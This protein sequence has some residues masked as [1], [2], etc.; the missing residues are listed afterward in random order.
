VFFLQL[1][2]EAHGW[3]THMPRLVERYNA[4]LEQ[5]KEESTGPALAEAVRKELEQVDAAM[6][7]ELEAVERLPLPAAE[8]A[9]KQA[10]VRAEYEQKIRPRRQQNVEITAREKVIEYERNYRPDTSPLGLLWHFLTH[11]P[12]DRPQDSGVWPALLGS[13]LVALITVLFAVPVGVAA[14]LYLEE[15]RQQGRLN[16]LIQVNINNLAGV[17]SVV[18]GILGAFVFVELIFKPIEAAGADIAAR[19][20]LG[21]GL[22][23]G[24]LTLPVIIVAAQEAIRAVPGSIRHGAFALGATRWQVIWHHVLPL[25]RPG[26]M[27]GTILSLSRAVGE[28]APLVLF[29]A[30]LFV[31]EDPGLFSRFTILPMQIFGWADLPA[32][33]VGGE[34]VEIWRYNAAMASLLLLGVL[35][36]LNAVAIVLRSRA[37]LKTKW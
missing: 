13:L 29:G 17:P 32:E 20:V 35:L 1:A 2:V 5:Q 11:G 34:R 21:G 10:A 28:A 19:N 9:A 33:V 25:A 6:R 27:T 31:N 16:N 37:Q 24:L 30:L 36:A 22:T 23:L 14:A 7:R 26:I 12:S 15:Y 8:R 3:F 4:R 18:Y